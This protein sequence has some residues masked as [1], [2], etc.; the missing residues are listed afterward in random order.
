M[1]DT[2]S[3]FIAAHDERRLVMWYFTWALGAAVALLLAVVF[4]LAMEQQEPEDDAPKLPPVGPHDEPHR[5]A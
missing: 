5:G 2:A 1:M 3:S 4:A